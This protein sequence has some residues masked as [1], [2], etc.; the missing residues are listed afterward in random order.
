MFSNSVYSKLKLY[1]EED[2]T[3]HLT[4]AFSRNPGSECPDSK[5]LKTRTSEEDFE[6]AKKNPTTLQA[7]SEVAMKR[8]LEPEE[9]QL[10]GAE[11]VQ[12]SSCPGDVDFQL[13]GQDIVL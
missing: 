11:R 10:E 3:C 4:K 2:L 6:F 5:V 1:K 13:I 9:V 7:L 12:N 8:D